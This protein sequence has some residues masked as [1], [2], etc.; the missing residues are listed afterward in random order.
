MAIPEA[1][2]WAVSATLECPQCRNI[3]DREDVPLSKTSRLHSKLDGYAIYSFECPECGWKSGDILVQIEPKSAVNAQ[4]PILVTPTEDEVETFTAKEK[5]ARTQRIILPEPKPV[6]LD[7]LQAFVNEKFPLEVN[8]DGKVLKRKVE[9]HLG[10]DAMGTDNVGMVKL[11]YSEGNATKSQ[12]GVFYAERTFFCASGFPDPK[13]ELEAIERSVGADLKILNPKPRR[14]SPPVVMNRA[15]S[16]L[17]S[18]C[19][20]CGSEDGD[21]ACPGMLTSVPN[22]A[23]MAAPATLLHDTDGNAIPTLQEKLDPGSRFG[24]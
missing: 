14:V 19:S 7:E 11:I 3:G 2:W 23:G 10:T 22:P 6:E 4:T 18:K 20:V 8:L 9:R 13:E 16:R 17:R 21:C 15:R 24:V 12:F 1:P 5:P